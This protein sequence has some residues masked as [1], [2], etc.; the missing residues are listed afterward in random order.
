MTMKIK[1]IVFH[2]IRMNTMNMLAVKKP[3]QLASG[4]LFRQ[5]QHIGPIVNNHHVLVLLVT[6]RIRS[7][8]RIKSSYA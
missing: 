5:I 8:K 6:I 1:A 3:V 7:K 2:H 4:T